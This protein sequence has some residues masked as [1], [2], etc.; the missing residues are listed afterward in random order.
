[1]EVI[2]QSEPMSAH[3]TLFYKDQSDCGL[4]GAMELWSTRSNLTVVYK[5]QNLPKVYKDQNLMVVYKD[6][7]S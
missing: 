1:M 6:Q 5:D 7:T 4:Q 2:N 3:L